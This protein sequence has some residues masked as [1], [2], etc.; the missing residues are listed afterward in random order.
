MRGTALA[1]RAKSV[2][3]LMPWNCSIRTIIIEG[4]LAKMLSSIVIQSR[5]LVTCVSIDTDINCGLYMAV[6]LY[7]LR[8]ALPNEFSFYTEP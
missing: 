4:H 7:L 5:E 1:V 8:K 2:D 3:N 6:T